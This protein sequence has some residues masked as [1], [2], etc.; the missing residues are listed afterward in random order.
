MTKALIRNIGCMYSGDITHPILDANS[1]LIEDGK[2]ADIG[3]DLIATDADVYDAAETTVMPCLIDSHVHV[4]ISEWTPRQGAMQWLDF[5]A[6]SGIT[7]I[8]SA[9][10]THVPGRP[11]DAQGVK[12]LAVLTQ[13]IFQK[14]RPGGAKVYAG[15]I[16]PV[17][18]LTEQ[19]FKDL[20]DIGVN[21]TGEI[22]LGNA[23]DPETAGPIVEWGRKYG[24]RT[25][26][27]TGGTFLAG[28]AGMN[29]ERILNIAPDVI[30]HV[31]GGGIPIEGMRMLTE[32]LPAYMEICAVNK[33]NPKFIQALIDI[34]RENDAFSRLIIGTDSPSGYGIFPHGVWEV[35][36]LLCGM[37]NLEPEI[38]VAAGSGNTA[39]CY[40]IKSN[41]I[42]QGYAADLIICDAPWGAEQNTATESLCAG[43]V[44]GVSMIF[45]DGEILASGS[46]VNT[47]PPKR[48]VIRQ[49]V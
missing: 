2:I 11:S 18:G 33:S 1:I 40:N 28:S 14:L 13:K 4:A 12:A 7:G 16:I 20:A 44:P 23:V 22:G 35:M 32:R 24:V 21:H 8:I 48:A 37:C 38:A 3:I 9:G 43:T 45:V 41:M 5:Y 36:A 27:H 47:A 46:K 25:L 30:C 19:D 15:A 29:A 42:K 17:I 31:A 49:D 34:L 26:T 10:E 6:A 39:T